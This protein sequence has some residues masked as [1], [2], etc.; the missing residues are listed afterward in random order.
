MID[1]G[2]FQL[3]TLPR[4]AAKWFCDAASVCGF[5]PQG[6]HFS[7]C[8]PPPKGHNGLVISIVRHPL[9]WLASFHAAASADSQRHPFSDYNGTDAHDLYAAA[10][11]IRLV[12][13]GL[14]FEEF[15]DLFSRQREDLWR[16][17]SLYQASVV[18][19][20]EDFPWCA[21]EFFESLTGKSCRHIAQLSPTNSLPREPLVNQA[22]R[23]RVVAAE[24]EYCSRYNYW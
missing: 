7:P 17:H 5:V 23:D 15:A 19:R 10:C 16:L 14:N 9:N 12:N 24:S 8:L 22:L 20:L 3:A 4:T 11:A 21:I 1:F 13:R 2:V 6:Y 18:L